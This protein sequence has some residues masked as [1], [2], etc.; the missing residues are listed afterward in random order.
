V[1]R[2]SPLWSFCFAAACARKENAKAA[3]LAALQDTLVCFIL[4]LAGIIHLGTPAL[5]WT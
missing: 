4:F 5:P 1:R 3:M 2:E